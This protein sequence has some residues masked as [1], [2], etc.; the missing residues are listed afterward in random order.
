M[1]LSVAALGVVVV[2]GG[3]ALLPRPAPVA[4]ANCATSVASETPAGMP[5]SDALQLSLPQ[6]EVA[7]KIV[8]VAKAMSVSERG[9]VIA[10]QTA[11][12]ESQLDAGAT[13]GRATGAFQ[14]I[15]PGPANAY[16]GYDRTDAAAAAKG[17]FTVLMTRDPG[18][19][20]DP[21]DNADI[22]QLVQASGAGA[23]HYAPW[24]VFAETLTSVLYRG[25]R[26][27]TCALEGAPGPVVVQVNGS[28]VQ[29]PPSAGVTG[30]VIAASPDTAQV[31]AA[32]LSWVGTTYAWG[33]GTASGPSRGIRDGGVAD[34]HGDFEKVGFDC[35]GLVLYAYA[36]VGVALPHSSGAQFAS[37]GQVVAWAQ[38]R[39]G[40]LLFYGSV[41]HHVALFLGSIGGVPYMVEAPQSGDVVRVSAVR[42]GGDFRDRA[43]RPI[44]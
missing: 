28:T 35:S 26:A 17:F 22:A 25:T 23:S 38:A 43:V 2:L 19:A 33:G 32:A 20:T 24:R 27:M 4:A 31:L 10:L 30:T 29:L 14:Q 44:S 6:L 8:G 41:V 39:P 13:V 7:K 42:T 34:A 9:V 36:Q 15:A 11:K 16:A 1:R 5:N 3:L 37:G 21:R 40:D 18:Y 12:Q